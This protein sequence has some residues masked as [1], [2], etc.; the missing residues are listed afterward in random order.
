MV[1]EFRDIAR[2]VVG[3][4]YVVDA[5]FEAGVHEGEVL[6]GQG[7]VDEDVGLE[8]FEEFYGG[9]HV[10]GVDGGGADGGAFFR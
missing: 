3:G 8:I 7:D 6:I 9:G 5:G 2:L 1:F 10:I 4:V